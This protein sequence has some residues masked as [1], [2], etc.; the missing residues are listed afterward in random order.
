[1]VDFPT[2]RPPDFGNA[3]AAGARAGYFLNRAN[4]ERELDQRA[5]QA[6]QYAPAAAAGDSTALL[7]LAVNNPQAGS[8]VAAILGRVDAQKK[9]QIKDA[10]DF[11]TQAGMG[12]LTAPPEQ[13]AAAYNTALQAA[14]ARGI[15]TSNWPQQW[16]PAAQGFVQY[17]VNKARPIADYFKSQDERPTPLGPTSSAASPKATPDEI[18]GAKTVM[19]SRIAAGDSPIVAAGW[20]ANI[21]HESEFKPG[22]VNPGDGRDG[23]DSIGLIQW[24][25]ARAQAL[26]QFAAQRGLNPSDP[27]TQMQYLQAEV[28]GVIPYSISGID[29]SFKQRLAQAKTPQ[30]AAA[31]ISNQFVRP[32]GGQGEAANR[33]NTAARYY[34]QFNGQPPASGDAVATPPPGTAVAGTPV[35]MP[36]GPNMAPPGAPPPSAMP[37]PPQLAVGAAPPN[38]NG[39]GDSVPPGQQALP[40]EVRGVQLPQ[41]A[42]MMGIKGIPVTKD[43]TVLIQRQDG[44]L[45]WV[46]LPQRAA[47][48][49][50]QTGGGPFAGTGMD[51]QAY[52]IVLRGDSSSPEYA[53]AYAHLAS[54]RVQIDPTTQQA[55]TITP[56]MSWARKPSGA[57]PIA[58]PD[59]APS[60]EPPPA[61][62]TK[63]VTVAPV[64]GM[65]PKQNNEQALSQGFAYRMSAAENV[66]SS[67]DKEGGNFWSRLKE[68]VP[69][70]NYLQ[71]DAYQKF[72]QARDNFINA[73]LRRESGAAISA[74]EYRKADRQ[75]F[76]QPGDSDAVIEQKAKNREDAIAAMIQ[77]A[78][79][80]YKPLPAP[81][82]SPGE[83]G[84]RTFDLKKKY[85]LE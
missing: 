77:N 67:V 55:I 15:D 64:T 5:D 78:G 2:Y 7:N 14:K 60:A 24:N 40:P 66:L 23:S 73:Q 45:D 36:P 51:A 85:G 9:Q 72:K 17:N 34:A 32:A 43:G 25:G 28:D 47:P 41:G 10:A 30:E 69:G 33:G 80:G 79:P 75:Y 19:D 57:S 4:R 3:L 37:Q 52:N 56:D 13:Q 21:R 83:Q 27:K 63:G 82:L 16:G 18:A 84:K 49:Q 48:K 39:Q 38:A 61:P 42:R 70:G 44:S 50:Q 22:A 8:A 20:A 11:T 54:P 59:G 65:V 58:P 81:Q 62:G 68:E 31:L 74:D 6:L 12:V 1:M 26:Q 53:A 29:P 76:P 71:S 46:P 35:S